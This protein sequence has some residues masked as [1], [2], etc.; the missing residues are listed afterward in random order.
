M[1]GVGGMRVM[2][3][4]AIPAAPNPRAPEGCHDNPLR[5]GEVPYMRELAAQQFAKAAGRAYDTRTPLAWAHGF[6]ALFEWQVGSS[7]SARLAHRAHGLPGSPCRERAS[8]I[9]ECLTT[10]ARTFEDDQSGRIVRLPRHL[11]ASDDALS[12]DVYVAIAPAFGRPMLDSEFD[13][14]ESVRVK[15]NFYFH[16]GEIDLL[17]PYFKSL[18]NYLRDGRQKTYAWDQGRRK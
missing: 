3:Y 14:Y 1:D 4:D 2:G 15:N 18:I 11:L 8:G 17:I 5:G 9:L 13:V 10:P 7:T 6:I 12:S 16:P